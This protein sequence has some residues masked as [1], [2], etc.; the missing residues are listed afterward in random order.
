MSGSG[1]SEVGI[2]GFVRV[3]DEERG[4][5]KMKGE[6]IRVVM[7]VKWWFGGEREVVVVVEG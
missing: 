2:E 1:S 7:A 3:W 5:G 4:F 6:K